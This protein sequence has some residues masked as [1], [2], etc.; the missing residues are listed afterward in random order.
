MKFIAHDQL[1]T[2]REALL[3]SKVFSLQAVV[4][5]DTGNV[6]VEVFLALQFNP[7][8]IYGKV[9]VHNT[10]FCARHLKSGTGEG[11]FESL[12]GA[13]QYMAIED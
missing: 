7:F 11:L 13:M 12:E 1:H 6:E 9:R 8:T 4:S 5:T 10:F 3:R 2:L